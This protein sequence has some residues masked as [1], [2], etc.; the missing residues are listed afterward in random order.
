MNYQNQL[1]PWVIHKLLPNLNQMSVS[2]FRKRTE[3]EAYLRVLQQTQPNAKFEIIFDIG[4]ELQ[5]A[6]S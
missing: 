6:E 2:R 4:R 5:R 3:A 1:T